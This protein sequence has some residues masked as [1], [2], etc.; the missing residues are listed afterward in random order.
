[1]M[2]FALRTE[3]RTRAVSLLWL[4][5]AACAAPAPVEPVVDPTPVVV[6]GRFATLTVTTAGSAPITSRETYLNG[7]W[8]LHSADSVL[9]KEGTL[10]I[11][12]RGN[13]TWSMPKKPY[14]LRLT[15]A[16]D[17]LGM[18]ASRHWALLANYAD[19]TLLR[20]DL[21]FD[22]GRRMGW[23][24]VPRSQFVQLR[25]NGQYDGVYQL[26]EHI[27]V[28][29]NR[30]NIP[31]LKVADTSSALV[32]GGYLL[33]IDELYGEDF[34]W[35]TPRAQLPVCAKSP[36]TLR[37]AGWEKQQAYITGYFRALEDALYGPNF[38]DPAVGYAAYIDV[39]S[40]VDY[41][42]L[43]ELIKNV[44]GNMRRSTF[45]TKPRGGKLVFG[46]LW[47]YDITVGNVNYGGAD[48]TSGWQIRGAPWF[49]R[50]WQD[51]AFVQR[52]KLRWQQIRN[53]GTLSSWRQNTLA[54]WDYMSVEQRR[55]FERWPILNTWVWPNRVVTGAYDGEMAAMLEWLSLRTSWMDE[56][57]KP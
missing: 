54:R 5:L 40:A 21:V 20:T 15:S 43:N 2:R 27:R 22:L 57:L 13:S 29:T 36:E 3:H 33:E 47:D 17:L 48:A 31:E 52:V 8:R 7:T 53:D 6:A 16:T 12:G 39:P 11:R 28:E 30:V 55:N 4:L 56:Q 37:Q 19:K 1:M 45:L 38:T 44:D 23:Q 35:N 18:P 24:Y 9:L 46:P 34:C 42:L 49:A 10:E 25:L 26:T 14:R 50:L 32:S 51:P 41:F